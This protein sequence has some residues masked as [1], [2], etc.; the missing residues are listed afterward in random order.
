MLSGEAWQS[1]VNHDQ[2]KESM[3]KGMHD[4]M[5]NLPFSFEKTSKW[6]LSEAISLLWAWDLIETIYIYIYI[7]IYRYIVPLLSLT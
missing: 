7:Y 1:V 5:K 4:I 6:P 2:S 3:T